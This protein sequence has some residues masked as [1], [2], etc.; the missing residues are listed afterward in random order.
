MRKT[1]WMLAGLISVAGAAQAADG[2]G[3]TTNGEPWARWQGRLSFGTS[4]PLWRAGLGES[5]SSGA[6]VNRLSLMGDYYLTSSLI[7][8]RAVGGLR[9]TGGVILGPRAQLSTGLASSAGGSFNIDSRPF[10]ANVAPYPNDPATDTATLPYVGLGYTGF[11]A[12]SGWSFSADLG[13]VAQ[14]PGNASRLGRALGGGQSLDDAVR[15]LRI[16]PLFQVGVN[17]AF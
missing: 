14:S 1:T 5:D 12:R 15:E 7:G 3:L 16:A 10:G 2:S 17:Y 13:L 9:A 6:K 8:A 11:A 4:A